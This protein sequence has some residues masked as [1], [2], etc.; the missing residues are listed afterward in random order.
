MLVASAD[1]H[2]IS[3]TSLVCGTQRRRIC[4]ECAE[5]N[6]ILF[7][8]PRRVKTL[9]VH[10]SHAA[11][12]TCRKDV[13]HC[14]R[15][16]RSEHTKMTLGLFQPQRSATTCLFSDQTQPRRPCHPLLS[17]DIS[18]VRRAFVPQCPFPSLMDY[19]NNPPA[20]QRTSAP[21]SPLAS[22]PPLSPSQSNAPA[23]IT[24]PPFQRNGAHAGS[25]AGSQGSFPLSS[26]TGSSTAAP[27]VPNP[28]IH[29]TSMGSRTS[30]PPGTPIVPAPL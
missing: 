28:T 18:R 23:A 7:P 14:V 2:S 20:L 1:R 21:S 22:S 9:G 27:D 17:G 10:N 26:S 8:A 5:W 19:R 6:A 24:R 11:K 16:R 15:K 30:A 25:P 29:V 3:R 4:A 13:R 12:F